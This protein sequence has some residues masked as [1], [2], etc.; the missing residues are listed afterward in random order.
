MAKTGE[1]ELAGTLQRLGASRVLE[2]SVA[3]RI[4]GGDILPFM[5]VL[6]R[7][8]AAPAK[9]S[10]VPDQVDRPRPAP[11]AEKNIGSVIGHKC[12]TKITIT[13]VEK[14]NDPYG[15]DLIRGTT[16]YDEMEY[17]AEDTFNRRN[18]EGLACLDSI[19]EALQVTDLREA[20]G[21]EVYAQYAQKGDR[22]IKKICRYRSVEEHESQSEIPFS[23][24]M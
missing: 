10:I 18:D 11:R 14:A 7:L 1:S 19:M 23:G 16:M 13:K 8:S 15:T 21:K 9:P 17:R 5:D 6:K 24:G 2:L 3:F 4:K 12:W 22:L 20:I